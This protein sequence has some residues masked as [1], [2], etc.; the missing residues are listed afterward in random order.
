MHKSF[1]FNLIR[2]FP[3]LILIVSLV[4]S[5]LTVLASTA[6]N[7]PPS[8]YVGPDQT[9]TLAD[10][11]FLDGVIS[12]DSLPD[13]PAALST[14]WSKV[15]GPGTVIFQNHREALTTA[16]FSTTGSYILRLTVNDGE[17]SSSD[18]LTVTVINNYPHTIRIPLDFPTIQAG[19]DAAQNGD[20]VLVSPGTYV[21]NLAISK[22]I[23][24][25]S[26]FYTTGDTSLI[27][28][29][30]ISSPDILLPTIVVH[31]NTNPETILTGF[32][33]S[34]GKDGI[35]NRGIVK[36]LNNHFVDLDTDAVDFAEGA[37]GL[38]Q[39]NVM[40]NNGDDGIDLNNYIRALIQ[41]NLIESNSG[42]GIEI[43]TFTNN[44]P[45]IIITIRDNQIST[46][47]HDGIQLID[48]D[49]I[50]ETSALL[51]IDRNL[52]VNNGQAGFGLIDKSATAEDYRAANLLERINLFNNTF[53]NNDHGVTG[54]DNLIALNNIFIDHTNVAV[55]QI[56][57][58]SIVSYNLF[59]NNGIDNQGSNLNSGT[60]L[61][62][63][64]NL[65]LDYY[66]QS[67]SPAIDAGTAQFTL[68]NGEIVLD[69]APG[70]YFGGAPDLGKYESNFSSSVNL[71][72]I[73]DAGPD[74]SITFPITNITLT[75]SVVDDDL[76]FPPQITTAWEKISGPGPVSFGDVSA[77]NT[78]ASFFSSGT[79]TLRLTANDGSLSAYDEISVSVYPGSNQ[80]PSVDAGPDQTITLPNCTILDGTLEDDGLPIPPG[81]VEIS[82]SV[83]SGPGLVTFEDP[84]AVDTTACF[85]T[86]GVY[87]LLLNAYD[88]ELFSID[89]VTI[90]VNPGSIKYVWLPI[91]VSNP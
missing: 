31:S 58:D 24:L 70:E 4:S 78:T 18:E 40:Q 11:V 17:L 12:D 23:T 69:M 56:D 38:V 67:G 71:P 84:H 79:Y 35:K 76:P 46:N 81:V 52:I 88:G 60:T 29:T 41:Q 91:T 8:V 45:M 49:S 53:A 28:Q 65:D 72:P 64:P 89:Q 37:T 90:S 51:T 21:E 80:A 14:I 61:Y 59:W 73:V 36:I 77:A 68:T 44:D 1:L 27:D 34:D 86:S 39:N 47:L 30:V 6:V 10:S 13:T 33:I 62:A 15:S 32:T 25:A 26:T 66:L 74:Q 22:T 2:F 85:S 55:K 42:D 19:I 83:V 75:G 9:I 16:S 82:W 7:L 20:L 50:G 54:G 48:N 87:V 57:G 3:G 43:R 5:N 63:D